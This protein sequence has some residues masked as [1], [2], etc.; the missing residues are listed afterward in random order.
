MSST[1]PPHYA[2]L[3][4]RTL[5][6]AL[7]AAIVNAVAIVVGA[8]ISLAASILH[9]PSAVRHVAIVLGGVALV[10]WTVGYFATF[11]ATTGQTP[12]DRLMRIRV[13]DGRADEC[14]PLLRALVRFGGVVLCAIP[15]GAG[16]LPILTDARRRGLHDRLART[17]VVHAA[18]EPGVRT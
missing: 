12:A 5:A 7:D 13:R 16:F 3:V 11:W 1:P 15:L 18:E 4:T 10:L 14:V 8:T 9:L 2:G 17:V 6:F